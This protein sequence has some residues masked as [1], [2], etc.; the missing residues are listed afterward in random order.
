MD[1]HCHLR[2]NPPEGLFVLL[3]LVQ[4]RSLVQ[5][6]L[7]S[8]LGLLLL[9]Q[10]LFGYVLLGASDAL[11]ALLGLLLLPF[12]TCLHR[13][14][15][16]L[17]CFPNPAFSLLG[18]FIQSF[19]HPLSSTCQLLRLVSGP[20]ELILPPLVPRRLP[21][22]L[23]VVYTSDLVPETV[24]E[25]LV[26]LLLLGLV[27]RK[28][29][30]IV[31]LARLHFQSLLLLLL[32]PVLF[33]ARE[34]LLLGLDRVQDFF[35]VTLANVLGSFDQLR[36]F[37]RFLAH[38]LAKLLV[39]AFDQLPSLCQL[40]LPLAN[41]LVQVLLALLLVLRKRFH[42]LPVSVGGFLDMLLAHVL[43]LLGALRQAL[44]NSLL[45]GISLLQKLLP[46]QI[47]ADD[48]L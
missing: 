37:G 33:H 21:S 10:P 18:L 35:S 15:P 36:R 47:R 44:L 1:F 46:F 45:L 23:P 17:L 25:L 24:A 9:L 28:I 11:L 31:L 30:G 6:L 5:H 32:L 14:L 16:G 3:S 20:F 34:Q 40:L 39:P 42:H 48:S 12:K 7:H 38:V 26:E 8:P 27:L 29:S 22:F 2:P 13:P 41:I 43:C 19:I 4:F